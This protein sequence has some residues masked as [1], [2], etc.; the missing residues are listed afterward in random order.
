M[1][2]WPR[3]L[4]AA[5]LASVLSGCLRNMDPVDM[6]NAGIKARIESEL[7]GQTNLDLR[8]VTLDVDNGVVTVS[9]MVNSF[10]EKDLLYRIARRVRGVDQVID[11]IIVQE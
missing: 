7:R 3:L 10:R 9:G 11:N 2:G 4:A 8:Y 1:R 5:V 6:T